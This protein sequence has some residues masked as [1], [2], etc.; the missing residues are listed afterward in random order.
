MRAP[1]SEQQRHR[2]FEQE[3]R[4]RAQPV[5]R[6]LARGWQTHA[7]IRFNFSAVIF[8]YYR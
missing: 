8:S 1:A 6:R 3:I 4:A 2:N 7:V 5:Q